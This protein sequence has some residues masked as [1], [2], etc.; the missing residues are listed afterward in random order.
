MIEIFTTFSMEEQSWA[1]EKLKAADI[2][3]V[4]KT[5]SIN[6]EWARNRGRLGSFGLNSELEC[7]YSF[8]VHKKDYERA[9]H[10][11]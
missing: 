5:K 3:Y 10:V 1:R 9:K 8:Y 11:L 7:Q 6:G 4:L 2:P